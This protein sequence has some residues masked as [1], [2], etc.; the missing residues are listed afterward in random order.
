MEIKPETDKNR[1]T[2]G[3]LTIK[4]K[5]E[6]DFSWL[7]NWTWVTR[8]LTVS[9]C[10]SL[11]SP[12]LL[13]HPYLPPP[14]PNRS[15]REEACG[16]KSHGSNETEH[17]SERVRTVRGGLFKERRRWKRRGSGGGEG[18][19]SH[20]NRPQ[21]PTLSSS[22][23]LIVS[24]RTSP[25]EHQLPL[26]RVA[27]PF[28]CLLCPGCGPVREDYAEECSRAH[29]LKQGREGGEEGR[30]GGRGH[31]HKV[32]VHWSFPKDPK[33]CKCNKPGGRKLHLSQR[34]GE[35]LS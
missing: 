34:G 15:D 22:Q 21:P 31:G 20:Q 18:G 10:D 2:T 24:V 35:S 30:G 26:R 11:P 27:F 33:K 1:S 25:G 19:G 6:T 28:T 17:N 13:S 5:G 16:A 9:R 12:S 3:D 4:H 8:L 7:T 23:C 32:H 14:P 29:L